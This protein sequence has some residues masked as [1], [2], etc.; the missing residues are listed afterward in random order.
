MNVITVP[1]KI[2]LDIEECET[3]L[4]AEM[5]LGNIL[6]NLPDKDLGRDYCSYRNGIVSALNSLV[7]LNTNHSVHANVLL[8]KEGS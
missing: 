7:D 5:L 1:Y 4:K 3:L 2:K 6:S 8:H